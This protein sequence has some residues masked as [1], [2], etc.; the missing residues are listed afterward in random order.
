MKMNTIKRFSVASVCAFIV[1][2]VWVG[3]LAQAQ[4]MKMIESAVKYRQGA[5]RM[6]GWH[7][8]PMGA[9]AKGKMDFDAGVFASNAAAIAEIAKYPMNGFID[10]SSSDVLETRAKPE[11][12]SDAE[13]FAEKMDALQTA[14]AELASVAA[15]ASSMDDVKDAFGELG[16]ACKGCHDDY[17]HKK[18]E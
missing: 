6:I 5:F 4:D 15:N 2:A 9:M 16:Q 3:N 18:E 13:D 8:G 7:I 17:R 1:G 10:G 14:S 11:I 12:W